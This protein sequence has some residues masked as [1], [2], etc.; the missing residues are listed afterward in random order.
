MFSVPEPA[1]SVVAGCLPIIVPLYRLA[2]K[3]IATSI[4]E[5]VRRRGAGIKRASKQMQEARKLSLQCN[6]SYLYPLPCSAVVVGR[7]SDYDSVS[8][9]TMRSP[10]S[11]RSVRGIVSPEAVHGPGITVLTE[12]RI[13]SSR[14]S[15][16]R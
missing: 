16:A 11:F 9:L 14:A 5:R 12:V 10:S 4:A 2:S 13:D 3:R 8:P 15:W 1:L 7:G 6:Q